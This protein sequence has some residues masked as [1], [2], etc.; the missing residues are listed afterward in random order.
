VNPDWSNLAYNAE[1]NLGGNR[2]VRFA[3]V[4]RISSL[5]GPTSYNIIEVNP[6]WANG[7]YAFLQVLFTEGTS[8]FTERHKEGPG[9]P[10]WTIQVK[11]FKAYDS[12]DDRSQLED[13]VRRRWVVQA[14]D[15]NG[16][17]R[18]L[19]DL[20]NPARLTIDFDTDNAITGAR[21]YTMTWT[22]ENDRPAPLV[23]SNRDNDGS[24]EEVPG[25][26]FTDNP[27]PDV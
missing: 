18:R 2:L 9:G 3:N 27:A 13:M 4:E 6:D 22:W 16:L 19:G 17:I 15:N 21:G 5:P 1:D 25:G 10:E 12:A 20:R 26:V 24:Y 14:T 8:S 23:Q 11:G 7:L